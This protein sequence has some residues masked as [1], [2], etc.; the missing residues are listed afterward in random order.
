MTLVERLIEKGEGPTIEFVRSP[1]DLGQVAAHVVAMLNSGGGYVVLGVDEEGRVLGIPDAGKV[2]EGV[3]A[4]LV[5]RI[6]PKAFL[7]VGVDP[8]EDLEVVIVDVPGGKDTP[9][10]TDG[11]V[12]LR[13]GTSTVVATGDEL[14][15]LL[16]GRVAG[17]ERWERRSAPTLT[18]EDLD[19]EEIGLAVQ[20]AR[21]LG[22]ASIPGDAEDAYAV[23]AALGMASRG[24]FTNAAD[25]CFGR[26][27]AI[28]HP[29]VRVRAFAYRSDR[30]GDFVDQ[31]TLSGPV[32]QVLEESSSFVLDRA[33]ITAEFRE[34]RLHR[35]DRAAYPL[36]VVRE[37]LV[38]A[39]A[40]RDYASFSG[41]VTIEVYPAR[42]E[43]WNTGRL[44]EGWDARRL[45][46][47]HPSLPSNPDIAHVLYLRGLMERIGRGTL[48]MIQTCREEGIPTPKWE[49]DADGVK[50]TLFSRASRLAPE[51]AL[52]DR[53]RSLLTALE[54]G[55]IVTF[56]E[57]HK[58]FA[59]VVSERQARRDLSGLVEADLLR[60]EGRGP[61]TR[62]IRNDREHG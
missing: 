5:D 61:S 15:A 16:Q 40:H 27:P 20:S 41:G 44:P 53:Q 9:F 39:L 32:A 3:Q 11:S 17:V 21:E 10:V 24:Q 28:R 19:R 7:D 12:L 13:R 54:P 52:N 2:A 34:D 31:R 35:R 23:L 45:R 30:G 36:Y 1:E 25:V 62:Y 55:A 58:R 42:V 26:N 46:T 4:F 56:G 51:V 33:P 14:H 43:I 50:L 38:N 59:R 49:V 22:R 47:T 18:E 57:Y 48:K 6:S 29:Q 37:G 8:V 60:Q